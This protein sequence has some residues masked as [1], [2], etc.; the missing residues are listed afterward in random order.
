MK[1]MHAAGLLLAGVLIGLLSACAK[2]VDAD[3]LLREAKTNAGS[4]TSCTASIQNDL[5]F[6]ADA[7]PLRF[8]T[9]NEIVY[10]AKP[11]A[12]K[13][14]QS[15]LLGGAAGNGA[16]YTVT[17]KDGVWFY[18][19]SGGPWQKTAAGTVDPSPFRQIDILSLLENVTGQ[20]YVRETTLGSEKVEKLE[21]TFRSEVL[22]STVENI[23]TAA[24]LGSGSKTIVQTL[25]D[26]AGSIYGYCYIDGETGEIA[27]VE[28]DATQPLNQVFQNIDGGGVKIIVTKCTISGE[29]GNIGKAP[30]VVLPPEAAAAQTV[31]A[32]G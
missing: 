30:A 10:Q 21:L 29:I 3:V 32:A 27:R 12:L 14:T 25:L 26:S 15:S 11:F 18:S 8:R 1:Q 19:H 23:V 31:Q 20:K 5:E 16:S 17:D 7:K 22:R 13:S 4:I 28:L 9:G 2:N 24:G 6:T